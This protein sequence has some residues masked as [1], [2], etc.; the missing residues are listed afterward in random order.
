MSQTL[1]TNRYYAAMVIAEADKLAEFRE[2]FQPDQGFAEVEQR[3]PKQGTYQFIIGLRAR[4]KTSEGH[5][6]L[7]MSFTPE[8]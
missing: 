8:V 4:M 6:V 3:I 7:V 2:K 1:R 5:E